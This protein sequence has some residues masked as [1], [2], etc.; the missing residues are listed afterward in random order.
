M[1]GTYK[2]I[3]FGKNFTT[4][5]VPVPGCSFSADYAYEGTLEYTGNQ[6]GFNSSGIG[7]C[8]PM[9]PTYTWNLNGKELR[10]SEGK[11][12][13]NGRLTVLTKYPLFKQ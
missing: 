9:V 1:A 5:Q 6:V 8:A 2:L 12:C 11:D 7:A 3:V 13:S 10:F 4:T